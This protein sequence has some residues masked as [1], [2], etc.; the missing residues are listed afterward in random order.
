VVSIHHHKNLLFEGS[1]NSRAIFANCREESASFA[2]LSATWF[3]LSPRIWSCSRASASTAVAPLTLSAGTGG[4]PTALRSPALGSLLRSLLPPNNTARFSSLSALLTFS[5][6]L[7]TG[8]AAGGGSGGLPEAVYEVE[9]EV[10]VE[11]PS[12][13]NP[14]ES[15]S[16]PL[17]P[18]LPAVP[19]RPA[20]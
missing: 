17:P 10:A 16:A 7:F 6:L 5:G 1:F 4:L 3:N 9:E 2:D 20:R 18:A 8:A 14:E 15:R 13:S 19:R 12:T 11:I